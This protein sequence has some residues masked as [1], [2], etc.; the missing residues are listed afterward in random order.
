MALFAKSEVP[1]FSFST[2]R[3]PELARELLDSALEVRVYS[4]LTTVST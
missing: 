2:S 3:R 4:D 1:L